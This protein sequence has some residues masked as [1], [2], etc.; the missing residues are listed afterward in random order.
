VGLAGAYSGSRTIGAQGVGRV[1]E[2]FR[3]AASGEVAKGKLLV[4]GELWNAQCP[5]SVASTLKR[6][7]LVDFV[8]DDDLIVTILRKRPPDR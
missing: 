4:K 5:L 3:V 8:Y 1:E 2:D 7:D 6:G